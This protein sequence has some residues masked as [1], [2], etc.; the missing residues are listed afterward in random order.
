MRTDWAKVQHDWGM[1]IADFKWANL[2]KSSVLGLI[3]PVML[4]YLVVGLVLGIAAYLIS[5]ALL[6]GIKKLKQKD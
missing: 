5:L 6:I 3:L 1:F 4:G 2:F